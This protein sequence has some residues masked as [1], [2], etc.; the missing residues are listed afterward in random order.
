M[1]TQITAK[2]RIAA[3]CALV[4]IGLCAL[5]YWSVVLLKAKIYQV[6]KSREFSREIRVKAPI[7]SSNLEPAPK[8]EGA[9]IGT[10]LIPRLGLS[11]VVVEG[12]GDRELKLAAGH[13][14]ETSLPGRRGNVGIAAHRDTFFRPLRGIRRDDGITINTMDGAFEYRVVST[15]IVTP[16]DVGVLLPDKIDT[17]TLVTCYPFNFVGRA[18]QR[19]IVR[20]ERLPE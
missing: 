8:A 6:V 13:I 1:K 9:V 14:P 10:L 5:G 12:V 3:E 11:T 7:L 20:A 18:P 15:K 19:F 4:F 2:L 17:L 16:D